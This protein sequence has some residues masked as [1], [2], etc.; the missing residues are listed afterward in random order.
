VPVPNWFEVRRSCASRRWDPTRAYDEYLTARGEDAATRIARGVAEV[1][2]EQVDAGIDIP[3]DGEIPRE[4]YIYYHLRHLSGFDF[5]DL[6][7]RTMRDGSWQAEVPVVR[8]PVRAEAPFLPRDWRNAQAATERP[9]KM[10]VPGPLTIMDSTADAF[11]AD[12]RRLGADLADALNTEIRALAA[13]GCTWIQVDE[14]VFA[15]QPERALELGFELL[16]RCFHG[17]PETV[18]RVV[19]VCCGYPADV[20]LEDFPKADPDAYRR[21]AD[22]LDRAPVDA[23]SLEDAHRHNPLELLEC[24]ERVAVVLGVVGIARTRVESVEEI[25]ARLLDA[26]GHI[27]PARLIAAPDCGMTMLERDVARRKL[28]HLAQAARSIP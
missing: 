4:H 27:E 8:G 24:F 20:D 15:R 10:T 9:V 18:R 26:L 23:V 17:L 11:Y 28:A 6:V 16:A 13:E 3:T 1:V 21:L 5:V 2:R 22:A 19:H 25:R 7:P 12:P 14:P